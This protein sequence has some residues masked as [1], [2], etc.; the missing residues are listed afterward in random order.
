MLLTCWVSP[1]AHGQLSTSRTSCSLAAASSSRF[2]L[3]ADTLLG[4]PVCRTRLAKVIYV[5][6]YPTNCSCQ[7]EIGESREVPPTQ[8]SSWLEERGGLLEASCQIVFYRH[9][10]PHNHLPTY[11]F[12]PKLASRDIS[13]KSH[14]VGF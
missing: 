6:L 8:R 3:V 11:N 14:D 10:W 4:D 5:S 7:P 1:I 2:G 9:F 12:R 13:M